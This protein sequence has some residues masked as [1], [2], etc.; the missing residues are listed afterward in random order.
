MHTTFNLICD[1]MI[2][3]TQIRRRSTY[4]AAVGILTAAIVSIVSIMA[5]GGQ[6]ANPEPMK[7][8]ADTHILSSSGHCYSFENNCQNY[9]KIQ[10]DSSYYTT[11]KYLDSASPP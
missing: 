3:L 11:G 6:F 1:Y 9:V 10:P 2:M 5:I 4:L 8:A 7:S